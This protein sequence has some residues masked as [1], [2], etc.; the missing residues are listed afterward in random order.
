MKNNSILFSIIVPVYNTSKYIEKCLD[1]IVNAMDVDCEV[2]IINDGSTDN[3]EN[4]IKN[5]LKKIPPKYKDNFI[6]KLKKN[7]GLADTKNVGISCSSGKYISVVDSDDTIA[8]NF[9]TDA[10]KYTKQDYDIIV[11][12]LYIVYEDGKCTN[13]TSRAV[14]E[15]K[16]GSLID[17]LMRG[18]MQ[19]SSCNKIIKKEL[20]KYLFPVGY[21][22]EDVVV[23][24]FIMIDAI[25]IKYIPNPNYMY[26]QR[27]NS[28]VSSN[29]L[30]SAFY[31][32][33][34]NI[35]RVFKNIDNKGKYDDVINVFFIERTI[36]MLDLSLARSRRKFIDNIKKFYKNNSD[37]I[38]YILNNNMI[39]NY[40]HILTKR[41]INLLK[42]IYINLCNE[43][44]KKIKR[45]LIFRRFVN[46]NRAMLATFKIFLKVM[47]GGI[48]G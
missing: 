8:E 40:T 33:C 6:Y 16:N 2:I 48:Y 9:Y 15:E 47:F 46:W 28:I 35:S 26:L 22:Y 27:N 17:K 23:T 31:K 36:D 18:A 21:Q 37:V 32:I 45:K 10:R 41:K 39:N 3:S 5:Y 4:I 1:S 42:F 30:D 12:D 24:P 43:Q 7:K 44:Y 11:Y 14:S 34:S 25:K 13:Y 20:Y 29:T 38:K 19:G